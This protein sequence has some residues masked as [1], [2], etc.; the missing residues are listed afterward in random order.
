MTTVLPHAPTPT[1]EASH[2]QEGTVRP[3][4]LPEAAAPV[5]PRRRLGGTSPAD[6]LNLFGAA[7]SGLC[8]AFLL[9]GRLAPFSGA[10]GFV[11]VA[12]GFFLAAYAVLVSL[13]DE[14]PV[15]RD[16]LMT[17]LLGSAAVITFGAMIFVIG[18]TLIRGQKA[19]FHFSF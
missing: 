14:G 7:A 9:F 3:A 6:R 13:A 16:K 15:V 19:L 8:V 12:Y 18:F 4:L 1:A 17:V 5:P 11:L 2:Q 10:L